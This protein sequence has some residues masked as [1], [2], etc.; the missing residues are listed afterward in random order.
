MNRI[1]DFS[2]APPSAPWLQR[3]S[4]SAA[5]LPFPAAIPPRVL[6]TMP[7]LPVPPSPMPSHPATHAIPARLPIPAILVTRAIPVT[8]AQAPTPVIRATL[9]IPAILAR[10]TDPVF[11]IDRRRRE[12]SAPGANVPDAARFFLYFDTVSSAFARIL[13]IGR[14]NHPA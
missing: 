10:P 6:A 14:S 13:W 1:V 5:P 11:L 12:G 4:S 9:A 3:P 8:P 7:R 2:P